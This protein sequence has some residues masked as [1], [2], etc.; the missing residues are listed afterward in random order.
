MRISSN[1][2]FQTGLNAINNQQA[3]LMHVYQQISSGQRMV[4]PADDPLAASQ[5]IN[6]SQ[7]Q[8]INKQFAANR[9]VATNS[10][11]TE[12]NVLASVTTQMQ[13]IKAS[14]VQAG[15][16]ALSDVDRN[17]LAETLSNAKSSLLAL[18][19]S[20]DDNG[21]Y[22][23]SG[24]QGTQAPFVA[25]A[26]GTVSATA[27]SGQRLVQVDPTSQMS[28][29][30]LGTDIFSR[31]TPG[32]QGYLTAALPTNTGTGQIGTPT[33]TDPAGSSVGKNFTISFSGS[34][35]QYTI[36]MTDSLGAPAGSVGP[37]AYQA[38]S[39]VLDMTGGVQV[40]FSGQPNAGDTFTVNTTAST[41]LNVFGT[42]D[43]VIAALKSPAGGNAAASA[44]LTNAV[45]TAMQ[46]ISVNYDNILTVRASVGTRLNQVDALNANGT[47]RDLGYT[48]Q[49]TQ[50]ES[51]DYY[52]ASSEL[53][54]RQSALDAASLAFKKI[55]GNSLF[56]SGTS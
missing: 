1:Q 29:S 41:D 9:Q 28:T 8:S 51:V 39:T 34:P 54:L 24:W 15:N 55:Q 36:A 26:A 16:G 19:N 3:G 25:D 45:S 12:D 48:A 22:I 38:G 20:T 17:T 46:K 52:S 10:L 56:N 53:Q 42:L 49:L 23:F 13:S 5:A 40:Q 21:Q 50:L 35:L 14:L 43:S 18:A 2:L 30:D 32:T 27:V 47:S 11:G 44:K 4:T 6:I 7:S 33:V 31:A 37:V